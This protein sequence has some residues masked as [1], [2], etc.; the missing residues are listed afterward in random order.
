MSDYYDSLPEVVRVKVDK[1]NKLSSEGLYPYKESSYNANAY[2]D[3]ILGNFDGFDGKSVSVAGRVMAK[4]GQGMIAFFDLQDKGGKIQLYIKKDSFSDS[5]DYERILSYDIGDIVGVQG[6]VFKTDRGQISIKVDA[7]VLLAKSIQVL[8]EKFHGLK[9][10]DLRYRQRYVDL[11]VNPQ[12]KET[13]IA[14]AKTIS[15]VREF[16]DNRGFLEVQTPVLSNIAGGATA[17]PFVTHH[18]TLNIPMYMRIAL[19]LPL[20]RLVV[21]GLDKVYEI[22]SVFRNEGMDAFHNPEFTMMESYEAYADY[23]AVMEMIEELF[24]FVALKVVGTDT[25]EY[26]GQTVSLKAPFRKARMADLVLEHTGINFDSITDLAEA[27]QAAQKL[28][29]KVEKSWGI[30]SIIEEAFDAFVEDKL[31]QPTFV[32]SYPIEISPLAKTSQDD[33]RYTDRFELFIAGNEY[34]NGF[35][36]LNDPF[37]QRKRFEDQM[38]KKELGDEE[39]HPFDKDYINALEVG[40]PPTGGVGVGID[41]LVMLLSSEESIRDVILFPTMKPLSDEQ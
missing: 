24:M 37:E 34:S 8:P 13:F 36:E 12:V 33:D 29:I 38:R 18:N 35:S 27:Q 15:A 39:T 10:P 23:Y 17:R 31:I 40:L 14:R 2:S 22:G 41:R 16:M 1:F 25:I 11:I 9:D 3:E 4:R 19:E 7:M 26:K 5:V 28:G 6:T 21:G 32:T 20:K 30:G